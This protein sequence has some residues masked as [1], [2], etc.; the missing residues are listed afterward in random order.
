MTAS[1]NDRPL[2]LKS[3]SLRARTLLLAPLLAATALVTG[4]STVENL[5]AG[6]KVDYRSTTVRNAPLDVPPDLSQLSKESRFQTLPGGAISAAGS[7]AA[8][9]PTNAS[10]GTLAPAPVGAGAVAGVAVTPVANAP[11]GAAAAAPST[12]VARIERAGNQRWLVSSLPP[13]QM[14]P[15]VKA[16]WTE[17]GFNFTTEQAD[18][19]LLETDWAENRALLP[20]DILRRTIGR[21]FDSFYSTGERDRFRIRIERTAGGSEVFVSHRGVS[22]VYTDAQR[23]NTVWQP[24]PSNPELEAEFLL[25][26]AGV[27]NGTS[28]S[29]AG[30]GTT[31]AAAGAGAAGATS[32]AAAA[33]G[34][35]A[36]AKARRAD[37]A[38][39]PVLEVDDGFDRAWRRVGLA[40]DRSGFTVE[41]RDRAAGTYFVRFVPLD[42]KKA[43][44]KGFF[45]RLFSSS[46]GGAQEPQRLRVKVTGQGDARSTVTVLNA[47]G[48]SAV[49]GDSAPRVLGLLLDELK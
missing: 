12:A 19:G 3:R 48:A 49:P 24:R 45:N 37:T 29:P 16:F 23:T 6:D 27:L 11:A 26:L 5:L 44:E 36:P 21:V 46:A 13:E 42:T 25:R 2:F 15:R 14:W 7:P 8:A 34:P 31:T 1:S 9:G 20:Q 10:P 18:L 41:D 4:C 32:G 38:D 17:R 40:L 35:A 30:T 47:Q 33:S 28:A 22:E 39:G 43:E